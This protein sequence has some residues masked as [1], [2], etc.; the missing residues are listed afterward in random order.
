M[1]KRTIWTIAGTLTILTAPVLAGLWVAGEPQTAT[2]SSVKELDARTGLPVGW[3]APEVELKNAEGET[4]QL[5]DLYAEGPTV[6]AF[7]R[8]GWCPFCSRQLTEWQDYSSEFEEAGVNVVFIT[9]ESVENVNGSIE[10]TETTYSVLSDSKLKAAKLFNVFFSVDTQTQQRYKGFGID[11]KAW[12]ASKKWQLPVPGVF[13][14]DSDGVV[15][16]QSVNEDYKVRVDPETVLEA[17]A[18]L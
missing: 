13:L 7:Y 18:A 15:Q 11:L 5:E 8:G 16:W 10:K 14:I 9:P 4:V 2:V 12:N 1:K 17:I 6:V 3:T